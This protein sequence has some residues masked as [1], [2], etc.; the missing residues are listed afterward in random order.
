[1]DI[2]YKNQIIIIITYDLFIIS[3]QQGLSQGGGEGLGFK[4]LSICNIYHFNKS[5]LY[6]T[7]LGLK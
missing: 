5:C 3:T 7:E 2:S 1:M 4:Y 6:V